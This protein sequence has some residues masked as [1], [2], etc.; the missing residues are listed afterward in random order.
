MV[1]KHATYKATT[2]KFVPHSIKPNKQDKLVAISGLAKLIHVKTSIP[3]FAGHW[4]PNDTWFLGSLGWQRN[5]AGAKPREYR[6]PSWPWAS[7]DSAVMF[8]LVGESAATLHSRLVHLS[9]ND[10]AKAP[11]ATF[12]PLSAGDLEIV[13][14]GPLL[15]LTLK[16]IPYTNMWD[17]NKKPDVSDSGFEF[18]FLDDDIEPPSGILSH[19]LA[20]TSLDSSG[21]PWRV[22]YFLILEEVEPVAETLTMKRIGYGA[23][24]TDRDWTRELL[25]APLAHVRMI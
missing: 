25:Q 19:A 2:T 1:S 14:E 15:L 6:A 10:D 18:H 9:M 16:Y 20:L 24:S 5:S 13:L 21:K 4:Y 3:Y 11:A 22:V 12:G 17:A 7:Q 23:T 8:Y